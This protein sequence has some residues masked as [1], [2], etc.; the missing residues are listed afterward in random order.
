VTK[1]IQVHKG[2]WVLKAHQADQ[3]TMETLETK[4]IEVPQVKLDSLVLMVHPE[5]LVLKELQGIQVKEET[6]E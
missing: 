5:K 4:E 3:E 1:V 2:K 6:T